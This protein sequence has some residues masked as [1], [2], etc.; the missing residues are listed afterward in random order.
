MFID[1]ELNG[2]NFKVFCYEGYEVVLFILH[3][4]ILKL[5]NIKLSSLKLFLCNG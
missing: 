3:L 2:W 5:F 1:S 4:D